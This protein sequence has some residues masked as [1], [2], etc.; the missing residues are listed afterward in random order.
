MW[1]A[2]P[3]TFRTLSR[4]EM[5]FESYLEQ[6]KRW[7]Q[8]GRHILAQFDEASIVVYQAYRPEIAEYAVKHQ[9]FGGAFSFTRMSWIKPNFL[10]MMYRSGWASKEGQERVL[11]VRIRRPAF[12]DLLAAAVPS[13]YWPERYSSSEQ[14]QAEVNKSDVR[15]QWDPDHSPAGGP[16][17]RRAIQLGLRGAMLHYY[18]IE[19]VLEIIDL[20]E[21]VLSQRP[22]VTGDRGLLTI[23]REEVF[24]SSRSEVIT[25]IRLDAWPPSN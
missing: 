3:L 13:T 17:E 14:W 12:E 25:A 9:R 10:W 11:G 21:F 24:V 20:T 22:N 2:I 19:A 5:K 1:V 6:V 15:L 23:P 8:S 18:A 16:L 4:L 7:P